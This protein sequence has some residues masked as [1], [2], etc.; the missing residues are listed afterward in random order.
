MERIPY[1][2]IHHVDSTS[3]RTEDKIMIIAIDGSPIDATHRKGTKKLF[4]SSEIRSNGVDLMYYIL[5][6][7][8]TFVAQILFHHC[9]RLYGCLFA[10]DAGESLLEEQLANCGQS[11]KAVDNKWFDDTQQQ[12]V[13]FA[14]LQKDCIVTLRHAQSFE[15]ICSGFVE[16]FLAR[17]AHHK[18]QLWIRFIGC[19]LALLCDIFT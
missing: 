1:F 17:M 4:D 3:A 12:L 6:A 8:N 14:V 11:G 10:I 18:Q 19:L 2:S 15:Y 7:D 16:Y 13:L 9:I 5:Q